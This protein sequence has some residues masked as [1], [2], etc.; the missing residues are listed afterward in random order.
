MHHFEPHHVREVYGFE[1]ALWP[2]LRPDDFI[3]RCDIF[4]H[5][6]P[7]FL[8]SL[9]GNEVIQSD[10]ANMPQIIKPFNYIYGDPEA[11]PVTVDTIEACSAECSK[12]DECLMWEFVGPLSQD[13]CFLGNIF[14]IGVAQS[15]HTSGW[16]MDRIRAFQ[17]KQPCHNRRMLL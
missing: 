17:E 6:A 1:K 14:K 4:K 5:F 8:H 10:W 3:R 2:R 11:K 9:A 12:W 7:D 15:N 13:N 16:R